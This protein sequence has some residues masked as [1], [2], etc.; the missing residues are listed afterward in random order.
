MIRFTRSGGRRPPQDREILDIADDGTYTLWRS[1]G[2]ASYPSTPVGRFSGTLSESQLDQLKSLCLAAAESGDLTRSM[3]PGSAVANIQIGD[4]NA[5]MG[6]HDE[7]EGPWGE[8]LPH[9]SELLR[10]LTASPQAALGI[11]IAKDGMSATLDHLGSEPL[12]VSLAE[13]TVRAVLWDGYLKTGDWFAP[14]DEVIYE[15][16]I[17]AET[18]WQFNLPF[19]HGF[20]VGEGNRVVA[21]VTLSIADGELMVPVKLDSG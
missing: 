21:Y 20:E 18:G 1:I 6:I 10:E 13:L 2:S 5:K 14:T 4:V 16:S 8:L 9:L 7:P 3:P 12:S 19:A 11:F 15:E 17:E